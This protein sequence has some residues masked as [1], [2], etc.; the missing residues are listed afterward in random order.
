MGA[1]IDEM[2]AII[3]DDNKHAAFDIGQKTFV[4]K[5]TIKFESSKENDRKRTET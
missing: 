5:Y 3:G 2:C 4:A 1:I